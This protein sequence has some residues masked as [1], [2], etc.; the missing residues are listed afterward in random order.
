MVV[1]IKLY[2]P[3]MDKLKSKISVLTLSYRAKL[4]RDNC[5]IKVSSTSGGG[6]NFI[7]PLTHTFFYRF[8]V[9]ACD[10]SQA[11]E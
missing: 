3:A 9:S 1:K 7:A 11:E 4:G 2:I 6:S 10:T 8:G 5:E